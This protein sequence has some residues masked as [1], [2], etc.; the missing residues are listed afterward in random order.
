MKPVLDRLSG[1]DMRWMQV[2]I[3]PAKPFA[4]GRIDGVPVFGLPGNPVSSMVSFECFARPALLQM[5]GHADIDRP[6]VQALADEPFPRRPDGKLHLLRVRSEYSAADGRYHVRSAGG[7]AS[8]LLRAMALANA[9]A[10]LPD[11]DGARAGEA[12][13]TL[14]LR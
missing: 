1:G 3:R 14:L 9:L 8:H 11:G 5:M 6:R 13:E 7:Q 10:L 12:V 2:G 4:F